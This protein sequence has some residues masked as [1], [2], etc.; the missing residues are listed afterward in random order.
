M[1]LMVSA[2]VPVVVISV[3]SYLMKQRSDQA[4][5]EG[6]ARVIEFGPA[7][8]WLCVVVAAA[9]T[10]I[11]VFM[12]VAS[13]PKPD[14]M[15]A[16]YLLIALATGTLIPMAITVWGV[17]YRIG[18]QGFE[19]RSPWSKSFAVTWDKVQS[20]RFSAVMSD[21]VVTTTE[22]KGRISTMMNGLK[23]LRTAFERHLPESTWAA[24]KGNFPK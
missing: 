21:F 3:L 2:W 7:L 11:F 1:G 24:V 23:D 18:P 8:K 10:A 15:A 14:D 22:G 4:R 17:A 5:A 20:V 19:K 6:D 12:A 13:P 16:V 9:W